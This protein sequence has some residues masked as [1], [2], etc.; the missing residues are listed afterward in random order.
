MTHHK[1]WFPVIVIALTALLGLFIYS[2]FKERIEISAR[3]EPVTVA[4]YE[5][6]VQVAVGA[7]LAD[8][9]AAVSDADRLALV[10]KAREYL[11]QLLV[12]AAKK[13]L[14]LE[15]V[16]ILSQWIAGLKGDAAKQAAAEARW[17]ILYGAD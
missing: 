7:L 12:P 14:H 17:Q 8:L 1:T 4:V 10:Q 16:M 6:Q 9:L 13:D 5:A 11:L 2:V 15:M 3:P